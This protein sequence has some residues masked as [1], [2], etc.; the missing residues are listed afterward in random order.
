M[1][2]KANALPRRCEEG[3]ESQSFPLAIRM[4]FLS[5]RATVAAPARSP[6]WPPIQDTGV[7]GRTG[8]GLVPRAT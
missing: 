2:A 3:R 7:G 4:R 1:S 5:P 6:A 8:S